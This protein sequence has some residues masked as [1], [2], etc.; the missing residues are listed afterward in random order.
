MNVILDWALIE[1]EDD[2][3]KLFFAQVKAPEWH[4]KNLNALSDSIIVGD[5]NGVEPPY[6][7]ISKNES[8]TPETMKMLQG[9]VFGIFQEAATEGREINVVHE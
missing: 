3:Y 1:T 9:M 7:V 2:F 8:S 4:G 5:V 6:T